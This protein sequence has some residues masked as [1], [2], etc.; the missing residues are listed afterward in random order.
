[1]CNADIRYVLFSE[2]SYIVND[3]G[4]RAKVY[5]TV[6]NNFYEWTQ[7]LI[8]KASVGTAVKRL[9]LFFLQ[10]LFFFLCLFVLY[11]YGCSVF[12]FGFS[13]FERARDLSFTVFFSRL[14][15]TLRSID[16]ECVICNDDRMNKCVYVLST[17]TYICFNRWADCWFSLH[18]CCFCCFF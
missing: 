2:K 15:L 17:L 14:V 10:L 4:P 3:Y 12:C 9:A 18:K 16:F 8:H 13:F 11:M 7:F 6:C 5:V 1:M